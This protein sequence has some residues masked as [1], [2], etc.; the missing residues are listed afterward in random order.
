MNN[1]QYKYRNNI[2]IDSL[3]MLDYNSYETENKFRVERTSRNSS[4][5]KINF[6][7]GLEYANY[8][9]RTFRKLYTGLPLIYNS[10]L[11]LFKWDIFG[12]ISKAYLGDHLLLSLGLRSDANNYSSAM[13]NLL[14]QL[15]PRFSI[16]YALSPKW[17]LSGN[18]GRYYQLPPYTSLGFR[19]SAGDLVNKQNGISYISTDHLVTGIELL[20]NQSSRLSVEGFYKWYRN[21]PL[22]VSDSVSI[23]SKSVDFGSFGDE[24]I[25][26]TTKGK[27]YGLEISYQNKNFEKINI[28]ISGTLV[29]SLATDYAGRFIPA[30]WDNKYI[31]NITALRSFKRNWDFGF[32]W[33]FV[34]GAPY[35]PW[36]LNKSS[37][38]VAW[39]AQGKAYP[40]YSKFNQ[41]RLKAFHQLD[42]RIDKGYFMQN[43]T[44]RFYMD[45]QNV[46]N[47]KSDQPDQLIREKD[48]NNL[49][50]PASGN[51]PRYPLKTLDSNGGGTILP[52]IGIII[53]F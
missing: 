10:N 6:G 42:V 15:S 16:S 5:Y 1:K 36:D 41:L 3:K 52:T 50:L 19:N 45:I 26:S 14:K 53:E 2:E 40:D 47:F 20:P 38:A 35:T 44:M 46:Y 43:W 31:L 39:D 11:N 27:A 23:S 30:A 18:I 51:P 37:L 34:G 24:E 4:G 8:Y 9:N 25:K 7:A 17:S 29:R 12:Q 49:L 13:S 48:A 28:I 33:R 21:Y 32:K 22:S